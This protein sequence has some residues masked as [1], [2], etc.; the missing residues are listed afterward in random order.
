MVAVKFSGVFVVALVFRFP[1]AS[2]PSGTALT[3]ATALGGDG[4]S[5]ASYRAG[6]RLVMKFS[7]IADI[8]YDGLLALLLSCHR[9]P[10]RWALDGYYRRNAVSTRLRLAEAAC[11]AISQGAM[12]FPTPYEKPCATVTESGLGLV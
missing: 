7:Q 10:V 4:A 11:Q 9:T 2:W 3:L 12:G 5:D 8:I 6:V 1:H